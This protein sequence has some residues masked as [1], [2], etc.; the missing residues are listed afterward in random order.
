MLTYLSV[1]T[2]LS[3]TC[4]RVELYICSPLVAVV[5]VLEDADVEISNFKSVFHFELKH[6]TPFYPALSVVSNCTV[7][8][9]IEAEVVKV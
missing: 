6:L 4:Q 1:S 8:V 2:I 3:T 5:A 9:L 7:I